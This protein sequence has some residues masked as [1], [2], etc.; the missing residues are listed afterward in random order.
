MQTL[1]D[2]RLYVETYYGH[3]FWRGVAPRGR[4]A[5]KNPEELITKFFQHDLPTKTRMFREYIDFTFNHFVKPRIKDEPMSNILSMPCANGEEAFTLAIHGLE[6]DLY[7]EVEGRDINPG[8]IDIASSGKVYI[9][10][11]RFKQL[12]PWIEDGFL[13][14]IPKYSRGGIVTANVE[15]PSFV[16]DRCQF[17][18]HDILERSLDEHYDVIYCIN[19]FVYLSD[20]GKDAALE[21]LVSGLNTGSLLIVD[22]PYWVPPP[23]KRNGMPR[24][25]A[26]NEEIYGWKVDLNEFYASLH[27]KDLGLKKVSKFDTHNVYEK[28]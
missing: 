26:K 7:I 9:P 24:Y 2:L 23:N 22:Q 15:V 28:T 6:N 14:R 25:N 27:K 3:D 13:K 12:Q 18:I 8:L 16:K 20:N 17:F 19:L 5:E 4:D 10:T 1:D 11:F 21:N